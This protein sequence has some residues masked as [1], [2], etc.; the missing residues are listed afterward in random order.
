MHHTLIELHLIWRQS[1]HEE[2]EEETTQGGLS[3]VALN[4]HLDVLN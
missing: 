2:V 1:M 4:F 3:G